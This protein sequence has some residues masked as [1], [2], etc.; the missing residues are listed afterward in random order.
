M[1]CG[2]QELALF[3]G[4]LL[5]FSLVPR[6]TDTPAGLSL[7]PWSS[8]PS[9]KNLSFLLPSFLSSLFWSWLRFP[10]TEFTI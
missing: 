7:F 6:L 9:H 10:G 8:R 5:T 3:Q 2:G 4:P 1:V